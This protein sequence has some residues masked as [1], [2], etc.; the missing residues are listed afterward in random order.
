MPNIAEN[1]QKESL[2]TAATKDV[3]TSPTDATAG[4]LL[5]NETTHIGGEIN[6]T[7]ANYQ[8]DDVN[9]KGVVKSM[10]NLSGAAISAGAIVSGSSLRFIS[11][12]VTGDAL[13]SV[14]IPAGSYLNLFGDSVAA[15]NI[16]DFVRLA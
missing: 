16:A 4:R 11:T 1:Y 6:Y 10:R 9:G 15:G 5:N 3:Q 7:G 8:P 2:G 14:T 13:G 12:T